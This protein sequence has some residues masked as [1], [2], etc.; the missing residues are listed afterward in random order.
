MIVWIRNLAGSN[1]F[2]LA[3][4]IFTLALF[5]RTIDLWECDRMSTGTHFIWHIL[6]ACTLYFLMAGLVTNQPH[7]ENR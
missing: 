1:H 7:M 5:F 3:A 4:G 2:V 6:I